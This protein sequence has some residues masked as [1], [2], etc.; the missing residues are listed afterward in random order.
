MIKEAN[1]FL[2][3]RS[4]LELVKTIIDDPKSEESKM[5][6]ADQQKA[7]KLKQYIK[8]LLKDGVK[9]QEGFIISIM[10]R[11]KVSFAG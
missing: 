1:K 7:E 6:E 10:D 2:Y 5:F 3:M 11:Q 9:Q 8:M 4:Y